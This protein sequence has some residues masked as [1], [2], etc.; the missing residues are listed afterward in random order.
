MNSNRK[1]WI[2]ITLSVINSLVVLFLVIR[3]WS[4]NNLFEKDNYGRRQR[5]S[6]FGKA[7][8]NPENGL[9]DFYLNNNYLETLFYADSLYKAGE[10]SKAREIYFYADT[11]YAFYN[12]PLMKIRL[13][14]SILSSRQSHILYQ[15]SYN[16]QVNLEQ[17]LS[18]MKYHI[19]VG[20][21]R[22]A[23][24]ASNVMQR[25]KDSGKMPIVRPYKDKNLIV[26]IH[27]SYVSFGE[28]ELELPAVRK[29]I[30]PDAWILHTTFNW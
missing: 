10:L 23:S 20:V 21:F 3:H 18:A 27:S 13:I 17:T 29:E 11:L 9:N 4:G 6:I 30:V 28:A 19:I 26:V 24:M 12:Y 25:V 7:Y 16:K 14:D 22:E 15:E 5:D 2:V 8:S 1:Y